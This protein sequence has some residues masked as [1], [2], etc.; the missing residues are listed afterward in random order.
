MVSTKCNPGDSVVF[1]TYYGIDYYSAIQ[2]NNYKPEK[3]IIDISPNPFNSSCRI[4]TQADAVVQ[5]FDLNGRCLE[6]FHN[7][8]FIWQPDESIGSGIYL[9]RAVMG[10]EMVSKRIMYMR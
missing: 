7:S 5:I 4:S 9:I 8:S 3:L 10:E 2:D 1:V 6:T